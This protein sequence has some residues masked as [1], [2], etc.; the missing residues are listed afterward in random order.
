MVA[1]HGTARTK[2]LD[3][4]MKLMSPKLYSLFHV[5]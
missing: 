3:G 5:I 2:N 1:Y 4:N